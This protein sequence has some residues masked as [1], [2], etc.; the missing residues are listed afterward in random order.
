MFVELAKACLTEKRNIL[1]WRKL[2]IVHS[3]NNIK[4]KEKPTSTCIKVMF[5]T[6]TLRELDVFP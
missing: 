6:P 4:Q 3:E 5:L 1:F 2:S